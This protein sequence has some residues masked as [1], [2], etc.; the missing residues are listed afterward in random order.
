MPSSPPITAH[1]G[2][3][4]PADLAAEPP[5]VGQGEGEGG[6]DVDGGVEVRHRDDHGHVH[7]EP[8]ACI[9]IVRVVFTGA[10]MAW[11]Q[12]QFRIPTTKWW[13]ELRWKYYSEQRRPQLQ[14]SLHGHLLH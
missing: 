6:G 1:L 9:V 3:L 13:F 11:Q 7:R 12:Q 14:S 2:V 5:V 10:A 8:G 4:G